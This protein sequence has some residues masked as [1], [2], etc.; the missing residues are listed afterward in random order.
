MVLGL[1]PALLAQPY[2]SLMPMFAVD[3][4]HGG[5]DLQGLLMTMAGIGGI[6]GAFGIASVGQ[7]QGKGK[8]LISVAVTF[9]ISLVLFS[10]SP[11]VAMAMIFVLIAGLSQ[12]SYNSQNQTVL[13]LL[14]PGEYRGRVLGIYLLN[15][16]LTP[17]GSL[18]AGLLAHLLER[19]G[20]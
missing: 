19:P 6:I 15:R 13:Q 10:R 9:G 4:F 7:I 18:L 12:A 5:A 16:S 11:A 3:V 8:M 14:I 1:V 20:R 17:I 2:L